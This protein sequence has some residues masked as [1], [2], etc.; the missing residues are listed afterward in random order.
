MPIRHGKA[1]Q[2]SVTDIEELEDVR[3]SIYS[4]G[5]ESP[6]GESGL[7]TE[8]FNRLTS[9]WGFENRDGQGVLT[10]TVARK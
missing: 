2:I 1:T 8:M 5:P 7:G 4:N 6:Q 3:V 9:N 10:F